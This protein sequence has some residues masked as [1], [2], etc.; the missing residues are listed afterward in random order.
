MEQE[1][2]WTAEKPTKPGVYW[3]RGSGKGRYTY[4]A[5]SGPLMVS[6]DLEVFAFGND[7]CEPVADIEGLEWLGPLAPPEG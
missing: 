3:I 4:D 5:E 1:L 6:K 2:T 7:E